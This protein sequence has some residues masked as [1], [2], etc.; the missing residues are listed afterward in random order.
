MPRFL[1][2]LEFAEQVQAQTDQKR[3]QAADG[4]AKSNRLEF[5]A[6]KNVRS[7]LA[8]FPEERLHLRDAAENVDC[9]IRAGQRWRS[10]GNGNVASLTRV[11]VSCRKSPGILFLPS[12]IASYHSS[13][14]AHFSGLAFRL[15]RIFADTA[16][17][18]SG[19]R[20]S[21]QSESQFS[22][23][24]VSFGGRKGERGGVDGH[25]ARGGFAETSD[26]Y[27]WTCGGIS[28]D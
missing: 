1:G 10:A 21:G 22:V 12:R 8:G 16:S 27:N 19:I 25:G 13:Q 17:N 20:F 9:F 14:N 11:G 24:W 6:V 23:F 26:L 3:R 18:Q 4:Q 7:S 15:G 2:D 28:R 5:R